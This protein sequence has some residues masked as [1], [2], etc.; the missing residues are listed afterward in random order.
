[1][2]PEHPLDPPREEVQLRAGPVSY[3]STGSGRPL[4]AVHGP[5]ASGWDFRW[6]DAALPFLEEAHGEAVARLVDLGLETGRRV[7]GLD[8]GVE[9]VLPFLVTGGGAGVRGQDHRHGQ[10]DR[11]NP[12]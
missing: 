1:M 6:L 2:R 5:P 3:T 4:V 10:N 12:S 7:E 9:I 8:S 11:R